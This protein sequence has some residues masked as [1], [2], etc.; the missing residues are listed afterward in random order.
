MPSHSTESKPDSVHSRLWGPV[1]NPQTYRNVAFLLLRLPLGVGYFTVFLTGLVVG[2]A[3]TPLLVGIPILGFV[4]GLTDYASALEATVINRLLETEVEYMLTNDPTTEPLVS[5]IKGILTDPRSYLLV[6]YYLVSLFVGIGTFLF[7]VVV[8]SL[9]IALTVAPLV[10]TLPFTQ[11][12]I[13]LLASGGGPIFINTL[14]E[15]VVAS[16]AGLAVLLAGIHG[17]NLLATAHSRVTV[18]LLT[19]R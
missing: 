10:Y 1:T 16:V 7:V 18:S 14:P 17:S 4:F 13:P 11:Y 2:V 5:Y 19:N 9:G 6:G 8:T 15:A 12:E 3:L